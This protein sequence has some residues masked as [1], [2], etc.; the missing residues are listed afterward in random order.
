MPRLAYATQEQLTELLQQSGLSE[1]TPASNDFAVL[2][3]SPA[4]GDVF[5][6]A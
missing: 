1:N 6:G 4:V 2:A 5:Q 3:H